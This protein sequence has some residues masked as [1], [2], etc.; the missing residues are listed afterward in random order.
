MQHAE[1]II[2]RMLVLG[3]V[4]AASQLSPVSQAP[5]LVGLLRLNLN[6][7]AALI[8]HYAEALRFC[9]L[10]GDSDNQAFFEALWSDEQHHGED[11]R[12]WLASLGASA[13]AASMERATF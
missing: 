11:L 1:R 9:M 4:P 10:V 2:Q 6:L 13:S 7:E 12:A 3:V 5:D 8:N